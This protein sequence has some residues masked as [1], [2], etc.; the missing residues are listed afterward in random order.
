MVSRN[1]HPYVEHVKG[2]CGGK[3]VI[4]GTRM[5]VWS[6]VECYR[7]GLSPEQILTHYPHL[8]LSRIFDALGYADDNT[9]EIERDLKANQPPASVKP[10]RE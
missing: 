9:Q 4:K 7:S 3:A 8:T 5:P 1:A 6:I 10:I 2:V